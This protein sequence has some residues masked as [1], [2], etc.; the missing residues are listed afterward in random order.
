MRPL[1]T[2]SRSPSSARAVEGVPV[3]WRNPLGKHFTLTSAV[4]LNAS[5]LIG[6]SFLVHAR[7][8]VFSVAGPIVKS[9]G[10]VGMLLLYW[11]IGPAFAL[12]SLAIYNEYGSTFPDRSGGEVV[13]LEQAYPQ[14]R[15]LVSTTY[16]FNKLLSSGIAVN[17][18]VFSQYFIHVLGQDWSAGRQTVIATLLV[19]CAMTIVGGSTK[20]AIRLVN[21]STFVKF[22]VLV[23]IVATG[24]AIFAGWTSIQDP[25]DN[26]RH[27]F[28]GSTTNPSSL[29]TALVKISYTFA[30]GSTAYNVLAEVQ[31]GAPTARRA[32]Y[33]AVG[34]VSVLF[35]LVN[36][37]YVAALPK[38]EIEGSG[39]LVA[40]VFFRKVFGDGVAGKAFPT[41]IAC[42][43]IGIWLA[44]TSLFER[45]RA[46][47]EI[48]R[49][50]LLPFSAFFASVRPFGTPLAPLVLKFVITAF[51]VII[52]PAGDA[53]NLLWDL[54]SYP[55]LMFD[56]ALA[57]GVWVL[58]SR[59]DKE[60]LPAAGTPA[61]DAVVVLFLLHAV[62]MLVMPWVPPA[63]GR[64]DVSIWY[65]TYCVV[66]LGILALCGLYYYVWIILLPRW[67]GYEIVE[68][69]QELEGGE[70][71]RKLVRRYHADR[72]TEGEDET[73]L[74]PS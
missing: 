52:A 21:V 20:W 26:F 12:V 47:R 71:L 55:Y 9:T 6:T 59:R 62:F 35:F 3:E 57:V 46:L 39:Q 65:A 58:R 33:I 15:L 56:V 50:G 10:S 31:G 74:P 43:S 1:G 7:I 19:V 70:K 14:P 45:P 51:I 24:I 68:E 37:A 61:R 54:S 13:Y 69:V 25:W 16:A 17:A 64:S 23:F 18:I 28:E 8:G 30:G 27:P 49:Q 67:G 41:L 22:L 66:G 2:R 11:I 53:A 48:A 4:M 40:A 34:L 29:A 42:G 38:A 5:Q 63:E 72:R 44:S 32:G 73:L 36:V 60:G